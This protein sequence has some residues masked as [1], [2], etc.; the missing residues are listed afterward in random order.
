LFSVIAITIGCLGLYGLT[1]FAATQRTKEIGIR[2]TIGA[3]IFDI[4][5]LLSKNFFILAIMASFTAFPLAWYFMN[6]WLQ[7]FAYHININWEIF[8]IAGLSSTLIAM[9]TISYQAIKAA[10]INPIKSLKTE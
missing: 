6:I 5:K 2:K 1:T 3:S 4:V 10:L 9:I 7:H 8:L